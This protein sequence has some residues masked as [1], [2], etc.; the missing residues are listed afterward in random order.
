MSSTSPLPTVIRQLRKEYPNATYELHWQSPLQ[1]LV[2]TI[3]AAQCPDERV[4][5]VTP[6]LFAR[7]QDARAF[8]EADQEELEQM[9]KSTGFYR[10]KAKAIREACQGLVERFG[11]EIPKSMD[12]MLTLSGVARKTANVVLNVAYRIPS[13]II[14]DSHVARVSQR[15]GLSENT[16]PEKIEVDLMK[17]VPTKEWVTFGPA[18]VLH[19]RYTCT[20]RD[21]KCGECS[22]AKVCPKIGV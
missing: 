20:A 14:V 7:Y 18:L 13:G 22:L 11:G 12:D 5:Q 19:G 6:A 10:N 16:K 4:N 9:V 21:P 8:A 17:A 3:L 1:L 15:L 2:A